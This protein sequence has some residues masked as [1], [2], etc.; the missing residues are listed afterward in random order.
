MISG[1]KTAATVRTG[2][3]EE[4]QRIQR[5]I[6]YYHYISSHII[7]I[8]CAP[9][10]ESVPSSKCLVRLMGFMRFACPGEQEEISGCCGRA[11]SCF[12]K[13]F[14]KWRSKAFSEVEKCPAGYQVSAGSCHISFPALKLCTQN[15]ARTRRTNK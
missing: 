13:E 7:T 10:F 1:L 2:S 9:F 3:C 15:D 14:P 11:L 12:Q 4:Y 5:K 8:A 6:H